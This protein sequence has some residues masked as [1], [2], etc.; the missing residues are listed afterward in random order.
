[1]KT[2]MD[3]VRTHGQS[4]WVWGY[5]C[6]EYGFLIEFFEFMLEN[7]AFMLESIFNI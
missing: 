4:E 5:Q 3:L 2:S 6:A 7:R 1:M